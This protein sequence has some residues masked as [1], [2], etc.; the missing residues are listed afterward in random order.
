MVMN[1]AFPVHTENDYHRALELIDELWGSPAGSEE[2]SLLDVMA[3]LVELYERE[4]R[5]LP[6]PDPLRLIEFKLKELGWS[7]RDLARKLGWSSPGRVSELLSGKRR[8]TLRHVQELS[9]ALG[10]PAG[11][12]LPQVPPDT[13]EH[14]WLR[15]RRSQVSRLSPVDKTELEPLMERLLHS[16][17]CTTVITTS[18]NGEQATPPMAA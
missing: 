10:L 5:S 16:Y 11:L 12:L 13:D 2:D 3:T 17:L 7:Q 9:A 1:R 18:G 15:L 14:V 6:P 4:Q 8:L